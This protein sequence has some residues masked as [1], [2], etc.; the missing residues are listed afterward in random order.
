MN[1]NKREIVGILGQSGCG[2]STLAKC[3]A[4]LEKPSGGAIKF[5]GRD[6]TNLKGKPRREIC[7]HIQIVFQDARASLNPRRNA[8][9]LAQEPLKYLHIGTARERKEKARFYLEQVGIDAE[10]Q[11][12]RPPQLSTGQCQ[13]IAI[14]RALIMEPEVLI[15]DEAV[16]SLDMKVQMQILDLLEELHKKF[17]FCII[18][19]SH[20]MRVVRNFCQMVA[21]MKDGYFCEISPVEQLFSGSRHEY[22]QFLLGNEFADNGILYKGA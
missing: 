4:G 18:M 11:V 2:K 14:A 15:C 17:G 8:L 13:R 7:R 12:R 1:I 5:R 10:T 22:T 16:S 19:I 6:I 3:I 20:D 21:V 9:Q